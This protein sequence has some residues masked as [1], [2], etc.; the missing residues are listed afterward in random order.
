MRSKGINVVYGD[1]GD[2]D[3]HD[4][5]KLETAKLVVSSATNMTDNE[6]LLEECKRRRSPAKILVRAV[7]NEH[8][9]AL[10][11]L[12]ADYVIQPEKWAF[13]NFFLWSDTDSDH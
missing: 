6:M 2:P 12:G 4:S 1:L 7:D 5:L 10:K 13:V 11:D 3:M 8:A 9:Q